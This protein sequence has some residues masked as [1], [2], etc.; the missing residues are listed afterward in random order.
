MEKIRQVSEERSYLE[1]LETKP[2]GSMNEYEKEFMRQ[3]KALEKIGELK[4]TLCEKAHELLFERE[5]KDFR[6]TPTEV[7]GI[8][9]TISQEEE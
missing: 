2:A 3:A 5:G 7:L 4:N 8:I 1:E 6:Y 9:E